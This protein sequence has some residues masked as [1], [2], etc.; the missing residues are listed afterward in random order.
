MKQRFDDM[1]SFEK[2]R[3]FDHSC[4]KEGDYNVFIK[5]LMSQPVKMK[6]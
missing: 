1:I 2:F 5:A 4:F 6:L 3:N